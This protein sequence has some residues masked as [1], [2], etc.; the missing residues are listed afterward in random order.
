M[1]DQERK[2]YH[3]C[4]EDICGT[5]ANNRGKCIVLFLKALFT[6][7]EWSSLLRLLKTGL[8]RE[9]CSKKLCQIRKSIVQ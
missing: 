3:F 6:E 8:S 5:K 2:K 9:F 1:V 7:E 4:L